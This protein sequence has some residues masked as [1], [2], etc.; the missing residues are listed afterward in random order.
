MERF[1]LNQIIIKINGFFLIIKKKKMQKNDNRMFIGISNEFKDFI[2][3]LLNKRIISIDDA[4]KHC[5]LKKADYH[6]KL[7]PAN[8]NGWTWLNVIDNIKCEAL[9][10]YSDYR[11]IPIDD[12]KLFIYD[13]MYMVYKQKERKDFHSGFYIYYIKQNKF[14]RSKPLNDALI[15]Y[16]KNKYP[17]LIPKLAKYNKTTEILTIY[18]YKSQKLIEYDIKNDKW[19]IDKYK[20]REMYSEPIEGCMYMGNNVTLYSKS[21]QGIMIENVLHIFEMDGIHKKDYSHYIIEYFNEKMEKTK[22]KGCINEL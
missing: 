10:M 17:K 22:V 11:I 1:F 21:I 7:F 20:K 19:N 9:E 3:G 5:W 6:P 15:D 4:L 18:E 2:E 16:K 14:I 8:L 12:E 13:F